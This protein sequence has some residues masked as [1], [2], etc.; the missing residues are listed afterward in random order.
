MAIPESDRVENEEVEVEN[1][2]D[3]LYYAA[4]K[5]QEISDSLKSAGKD[6]KELEKD[7]PIIDRLWNKYKNF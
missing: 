5:F 6:I 7:K 3:M 4:K 2:R 1:V